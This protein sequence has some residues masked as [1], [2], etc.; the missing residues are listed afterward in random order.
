MEETYNKETI[1]NFD[2][3]LLNKVIQML[4]RGFPILTI[5]RE[6]NLPRKTIYAIKERSY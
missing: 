1:K 3:I 2:P 6:L 5:A 4:N